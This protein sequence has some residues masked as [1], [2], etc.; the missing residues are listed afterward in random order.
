MKV[1]KYTGKFA[2]LNDAIF[3]LV[4]LSFIFVFPQVITK[5]E[6]LG[7]MLSSGAYMLDHTTLSI[8]NIILYTG[9]NQTWIN[10]NW[11]T[12]ILFTLIYRL[13]GLKLI[14]ITCGILIALVFT[15]IF[16]QMMQKLNN[17]PVNIALLSIGIVAGSYFVDAGSRLITYMLF[18]AY[19]CLLDSIC[20][21]GFKK[22]TVV[23][24]LITS[25]LW[26]NINVNF[27]YGLLIIW[28]YMLAFYI[29]SKYHKNQE[30]FLISKNFLLLFTGC[31]L[32][33]FINPAGFKLHYMVF[34]YIFQGL[35]IYN[36]FIL[37]PD[38]HLKYPFFFVELVILLLLFVAV[39]SGYRPALQKIFITVIFL[40]ITLYAAVNTMFLLIIVLPLISEV[41]ANTEFNR[42]WPWLEKIKNWSKIQQSFSRH[43]LSI[44]VA[45]ILFMAGIF[46]STLEEKI[47]RL[48]TYPVKAVQH[49]SKNYPES[50]IF[51]PL[52][53]GCYLHHYA[54]C[55]VFITERMFQ[56]NHR[57]L[58]DYNMIINIYET[59]P[60]L[61]K[62]YD[63]DIVMIPETHGLSVALNL[64]KNW[65]KIYQ[66]T[67]TVLYKKE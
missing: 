16:N 17:W 9:L 36:G 38:F 23:I 7:C 39:F 5:S 41:I 29:R 19:I 31:L 63:V 66:D 34:D 43:T 57:T 20:K 11:L 62:A 42:Q 61:L 67:R 6:I 4:A 65:N 64:D 18:F 49:L 52:G 22:N 15:L 1:S 51:N 25:I 32:V 13:G 10:E 56:P 53:W 58:Y 50:K 27:L 24:I 12:D 54:G 40:F 2:T 26:A 48:P 47:V 46:I 33:S 8:P 14:V 28:L 30:L 44:L 60:E 21:D 59:Y 35:Y 3:I 45:I 55:R 37:S